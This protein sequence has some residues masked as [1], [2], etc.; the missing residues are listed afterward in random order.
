MVNVGGKPGHDELPKPE[1]LYCHPLAL[2]ELLHRH[3]AS[4]ALML[5]N[6]CLATQFFG[7]GAGYGWKLRGLALTIIVGVSSGVAVA[8]GA[9][10]P[11]CVGVTVGVFSTLTLGEASGPVVGILVAGAVADP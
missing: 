10:A 3:C 8:E 9:G 4:T 2:G 6:C 1:V 7:F 5:V 11:V